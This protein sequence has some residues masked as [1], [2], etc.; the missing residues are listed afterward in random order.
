MWTVIGVIVLCI[1]FF[2]DP[3]MTIFVGVGFLL[4]GVVG[5][6]IGLVLCFVVAAMMTS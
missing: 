1:L 5:A 6:I 4:G 2:I 3:W